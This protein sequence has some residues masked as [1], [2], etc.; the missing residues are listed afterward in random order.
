V[1]NASL[2]QISAVLGKNPRAPGQA[3]FELADNSHHDGTYCYCLGTEMLWRMPPCN[4]AVRSHWQAC[5]HKYLL[6]YAHRNPEHS[7]CNIAIILLRPLIVGTSLLM[8]YL[9][10]FRS[11]GLHVCGPKV[12]CFDGT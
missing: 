12:D 8:V 1:G 5:V 7:A 9:H 6:L 11:M 10:S 3:R 4:Y 2:A